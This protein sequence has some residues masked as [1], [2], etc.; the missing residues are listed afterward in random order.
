MLLYVLMI[1]VICMLVGALPPAPVFAP[2]PSAPNAI[3]IVVVVLLVLVLLGVL[4]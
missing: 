2:G 4:R 3:A 1:L